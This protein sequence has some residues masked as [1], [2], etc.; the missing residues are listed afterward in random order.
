MEKPPPSKTFNKI[1]SL[2]DSQSTDNDDAAQNDQFSSVKETLTAKA[3][4]EAKDDT[5]EE[6]YEVNSDAKKPE[7]VP[8]DDSLDSITPNGLKKLDIP[9]EEDKS[10]NDENTQEKV[11]EQNE[12]GNSEDED[13]E[14]LPVEKILKAAVLQDQ[15]IY[16]L[17][18]F[19]GIAKPRKVLAS[20]ANKIF[21]SAVIEFYTHRI[22]WT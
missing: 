19:K 13:I 2:E 11:N 16:F 17:I 14:N 12:N 4:D 15:K 18:K 9:I 22:K 21:P 3:D 5:N 10:D 7:N 6:E 20:Q 1:V 8:D